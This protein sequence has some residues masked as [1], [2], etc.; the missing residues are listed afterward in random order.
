MFKEESRGHQSE[1]DAPCSSAIVIGEDLA[2]PIDSVVGLKIGTAIRGLKTE[3]VAD[4]GLGK[5]DDVFFRFG[6][7]PMSDALRG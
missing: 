2:R 6:L 5:R 7:Q 1:S 3:D 4:P